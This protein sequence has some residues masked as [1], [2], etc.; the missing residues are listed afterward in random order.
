MA[1]L[2][3]IDVP[4]EREALLLQRQQ[5]VAASAHEIRRFSRRALGRNLPSWSLGLV[6]SAW[7][8][9]VGNPLE[10]VFSALSLVSS[11]LGLKSPESDRVTAYSYLFRVEYNFSVRNEPFRGSQRSR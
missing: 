9:V 2:A 6:G 8:A 3:D 11:V 10:T 4:K 5:E 7:S 1:E